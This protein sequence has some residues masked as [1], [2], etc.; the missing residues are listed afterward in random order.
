MRS[1]NGI[2]VVG[3]GGKPV[4]YS[5]N[6]L[7]SLGSLFLISLANGLAKTHFCFGCFSICFGFAGKVEWRVICAYT[8]RCTQVWV[9][10]EARS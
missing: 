5:V 9:P 1:G 6:D 2:Q 10:I 4:R 7:A 3:V 8:C